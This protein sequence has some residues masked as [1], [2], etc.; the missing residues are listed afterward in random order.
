MMAMI[1]R[2]L[3]ALIRSPS[4]AK[5]KS[6]SAVVLSAT[7]S[8]VASSKLTL[9]IYTLLQSVNS[10]TVSLRRL[11]ARASFEAKLFLLG[12]LSVIKRPSD[13]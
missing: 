5:T 12:G 13:A 7:L 8:R 9:Q 3:A 4:L 11:Q 6:R 10:L 1:G 2:L